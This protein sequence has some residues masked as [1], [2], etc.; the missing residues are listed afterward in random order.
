MVVLV[1]GGCGY[2]G[3]KLIR[4]MVADPKFS[5]T[6]IRVIDT[7]MRERYVASVDLPGK[8]DFEFLEGD[9]RKDEDLKN[10]FRDVDMVVDLAG[11]TNAPFPSSAENLP[12]M[13]MS[14][15]AEKS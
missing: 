3:S 14:M 1:T 13:L 10:A 6:T 12:S 4:D 2:I 11:I 8:S 5:G 15:A 9:I 7:M